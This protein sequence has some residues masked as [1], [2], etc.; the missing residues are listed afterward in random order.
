L[1]HL[2]FPTYARGPEV[3]GKRGAVLPPPTDV[4]NLATGDEIPTKEVAQMSTSLGL[5]LTTGQ[6]DLW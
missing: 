3:I 6:V 1:T 5:K 4:E 2:A